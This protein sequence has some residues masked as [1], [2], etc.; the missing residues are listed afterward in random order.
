MIKS[1]RVMVAVFAL[2]TGQMSF[3]QDATPL[4]G[5]DDVDVRSAPR[6][7][8]GGDLRALIE[9][10]LVRSQKF[11][12]P[13][14][15]STA[16]AIR[17]KNL[18]DQGVGELV[19]DPL[20]YVTYLVT[21]RVVEFSGWPEKEESPGLIGALFQV[22]SGAGKTPARKVTLALDV[23]ISD[24][25]SGKIAFS[26][27][28]KRTTTIPPQKRAFDLDKDSPNAYLPI[29]V[30]GIPEFHTLMSDIAS[31]ISKKIVLGTYP[32]TVI[33]YKDGTAILN[34]GSDYVT[35]GSIYEVYSQGADLIDPATKKVIG[36]DEQNLG[37]IK[38]TKVL[39]GVSYGTFSPSSPKQM[40]SPIGAYARKI[41]QQKSGR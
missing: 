30:N 8:N 38:I 35:V 33:S 34:Y 15:S 37:R 2:A 1:V 13:E 40:L 10:N 5:V 32:I 12:L 21:S 41:D 39:D 14:R 36:T 20:N 9:S 3:A 23:R 17:Y 27:I 19:P 26:G 11:S 6:W 25:R 4:V 7:F 18:R 16:Q 29:D 31:D 24:L 28:V 22:A